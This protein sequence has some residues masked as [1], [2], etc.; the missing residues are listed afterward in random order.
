MHEDR[1]EADP[2]TEEELA[3]LEFLNR[4]GEKL[5]KRLLKTQHQAKDINKMDK[6]NK[7]LTKVRSAKLAVA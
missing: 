3:I 6:A 4:A 1:T 2:F 5:N 7:R